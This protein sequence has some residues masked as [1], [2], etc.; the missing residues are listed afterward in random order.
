MM[1][2]E[3]ANISQRVAVLVDGNNIGIAI[4]E[5]TKDADAMLNFKTFI[6]K[7]LKGRGLSKLYFFREGKTISDK[8]RKLLHDEFHGTVIPCGKS[9]D[10]RMAI[11][12]TETA[13]KVDTII[14]MTGDKDFIPL[15][16]HLRSRGVRV[17]IACVSSSA[18]A[19]LIDEADYFCPITE[20]D[21]Y[22]FK[23]LSRTSA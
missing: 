17:E 8:L 2:A 11:T 6:P 20:G 15:V 12:A 1:E 18:S 19:E 21:I 14:L 9:A 10:V 16:E 3:K 4:H 5:F 13:D 22:F 23:P 7:I